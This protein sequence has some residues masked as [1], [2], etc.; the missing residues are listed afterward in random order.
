[1]LIIY[2]G[3]KII[4]CGSKIVCCGN[5]ISFL[6]EQNNKLW[7]QDIILK[8]KKKKFLRGLNQRLLV[9]K[10]DETI[11]FQLEKNKFVTIDLPTIFSL[12]RCFTAGYIL[13]L[14]VYKCK[15]NRRI[16]GYVISSSLCINMFGFLGVF[17]FCWICDI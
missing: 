7:E 13:L 8:K 5:K 14:N 10:Q 3:N 16:L 11:Y 1:M 9:L 15:H 2:W 12:M 6:W 17:F 4:C